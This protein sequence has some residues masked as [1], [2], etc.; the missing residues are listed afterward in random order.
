[1]GEEKGPAGY[2]QGLCKMEFSL[3]VINFDNLFDRELS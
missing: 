1:M 2:Y 3:F